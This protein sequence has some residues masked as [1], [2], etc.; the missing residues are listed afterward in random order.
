MGEATSGSGE[1]AF[2]ASEPLDLTSIP[3]SEPV[4]RGLY[5]FNRGDYGLSEHYF[6]AAV[7]K[8]PDNVTAWIGL[9]ASYD[10]DRRFE[11]ADRAYAEAIH[12]A[13]ETTQILNNQGYSYMLRGDFK[14]AHA[15]F[16][17]ALKGDPDNK[18]IKNNLRILEAKLRRPAPR[19]RE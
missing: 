6:R 14:T 1:D 15:K 5:H 11:L 3:T 12:I 10:K 7:E 13:G 16:E 19:A 17:K 4:G 9:A 2:D 18:I 8:S